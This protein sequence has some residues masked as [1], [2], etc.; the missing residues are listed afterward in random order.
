MEK[1]FLRSC[2][3]HGTRDLHRVQHTHLPSESQSVAPDHVLGGLTS[4]W[5]LLWFYRE[6]AG[7]LQPRR[8][9]QGNIY[10]TALI[11]A[12]ALSSKSSLSMTILETIL[13][14]KRGKGQ[15]EPGHAEPVRGPPELHPLT[16]QGAQ[17]SE[18]RD[19]PWSSPA[20]PSACGA[21]ASGQQWGPQGHQA[22][23]SGL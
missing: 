20:A 17:D 22:V 21:R 1:K 14:V 12:S 4:P 6:G 16:K 5:R 11:K 10:P 13:S 9:V 7:C 2:F 19:H 18:T 3:L 23:L 15:E 8:G